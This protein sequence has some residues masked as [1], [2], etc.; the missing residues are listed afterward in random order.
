MNF[1]KDNFKI[2]AVLFVLSI[3]NNSHAQ[4]FWN[5][6]C[7]FAGTGTSYIS[8]PNSAG[9]NLTGDFTLEAWVNPT[10]VSGTEKGI[11][12]KGSVQGISLRYAVKI[13][14]TGR[15][16]ISTN[17]VL[18]LTS[19]TALTINTWTHVCAT[20]NSTTDS[21]AIY[22]NG[23]KN[24]G[25][26]VG[27]AEPSSNT[28]S[29]F[30]GVAGSG[31]PFAGQLDEVR[32][33][34]KSLTATQISQYFR[35]SLSATSGRLYD[36]LVMSMPFQRNNSGGVVF[37]TDDN[38]GN[39]NNGKGR[40]VTAV[41][42]TGTNYRTI[43]ANESLNL[44]GSGEYAAGES[45]SLVSPTSQ[46]TLEAWVYP[47]S[48]TNNPSV[49]SK[50]SASSYQLGVNSSG[51]VVFNPKGGA[52]L[53]ESK[54]VVI[55]NRWTHIA[56]AYNGSSASI[57]INGILDTST[58]SITGAIGS[59]SDSLL[60]GADRPAGSLVNFF[61]GLIDEVRISNYEKTPSQ[62]SSYLYRSIDS[63]NQPAPA[64]N[65]VCYNLDGALSD[66]ADGGPRLYMRD[67]A[68]FSH[69][70]GVANMPVSPLL[71]DDS[72]NFSPGFT[73]RNS[74]KRVP[75][76]GGSG[77][78]DDTL[79]IPFNVN[80]N[81]LN[82]FL[83][84]NH[85][86]ETNLD[87]FLIAPNGETAQLS[88]DGVTAGAYD[89]LITVFDDQ[90]ANAVTSTVFTSFAP[91]IRP[92]S[93]LFRAFGGD[94]SLGRWILRVTDD[95]GTADTGRLISWGIQF[96]TSP[97]SGSITTLNL[98]SII[99]GFWDGVVMAQ[100]TMRVYLRNTTPPY[101]ITD[102]SKVFLSSLGFANIS[103]ANTGT[104]TKYITLKHRNSLQTWS[105]AGVNFK[106]DSTTT[107]DFTTAANK[108]YGNNQVLQN[109]KFTLYNG[110]VN[111]DL[112]IDLTDLIEVY[113]AGN[114]FTVGYDIRDATGDNF[115][116]LND[117]IPVY[118]NA[119][120]F[121]TQITPP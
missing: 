75:L 104:S 66:N 4:M 19:T 106:Q 98:T 56:A 58:N 100:D 38:T 87:V 30:I 71:R 101:V 23:V 37:T 42:E 119:S 59:N 86:D 32:L 96:N 113:N 91:S 88:T 54:T 121:V 26:V 68:K 51:K 85:F 82:I 79:I 77:T 45:T 50:N 62:I 36:G 95:G 31:L 13:S 67:S 18:R 48:L 12:S 108:A 9:V 72:K 92:D 116:D 84:I 28:D 39:G 120:N 69:P 89:N 52:S 112:S 76:T 81:D 43:S 25:A 24:I 33:W 1:L 20:F 55:T 107:Y 27:S 11:I 93:N 117:L 74:G 29:L 47:R 94:Y 10:S 49:I 90:A 8:V 64:S 97:I 103:F 63:V 22:L 7:Q 102:S 114:A 35:T 105:A 118:N 109:G 61:N 83:A 99:Q 16:T 40:N 73:I 34:N 15:V 53:L 60:I 115:V 80:I 70:G 17:G 2:F 46:I 78:T 110:N 5:Q 111:G 44:F 21:F 65:N 41:S 57:F 3:G 14:T 6:T